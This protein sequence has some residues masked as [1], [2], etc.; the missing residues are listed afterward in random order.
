MEVIL[1]YQ[2]KNNQVSWT[3]FEFPSSDEFDGFLRN[4]VTARLADIEG[5]TEFEQYLRGLANTGFAN[6]NIDK[7]L[8]AAIPEERDW[9]VGEALAESWLSQEHSVVWP[10]NMEKDKRNPKASLPGADL[11][12]FQRDGDS[13]VL[14]V[15]EVKTSSERKSPPGVMNGRSGM[16]NQLDS[17]ANDLSLIGQLLRW[18]LPRCKNT[19]YEPL[20]QS[21]VSTYF[22]SG[23]RE[24]AL[25]GVLIRD[26]EA[27][28]SDLKSRG[29][30]LSK[31]I[32]CPTRC[33]LLALY[34]PHDISSLPSYVTGGAS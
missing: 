4:K 3:G 14:V 11:I 29:N 5:K 8:N 25:F 17:L 32:C 6:E 27:N 15:G 26:T 21:A 31:I 30:A 9:A 1:K 24:L 34:I 20:F 2:S 19:K 12:G 23:N 18:L 10:W 28:E 13:T 33:A 22:E 7:V 16:K